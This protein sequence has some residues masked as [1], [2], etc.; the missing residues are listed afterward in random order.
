M[1]SIFKTFPRINI[2]PLAGWLILITMVGATIPA[3]KEHVYTPWIIATVL[4]AFLYVFH[5]PRPVAFALVLISIPILMFVFPPPLPLLKPLFQFAVIALLWAPATVISLTAISIISNHGTNQ[6]QSPPT[7][8][9]ASRQ[10]R[11]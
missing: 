10:H 1:I 6:N 5:S 3:F 2:K 11:E 9:E 8:D 7:P 4:Y